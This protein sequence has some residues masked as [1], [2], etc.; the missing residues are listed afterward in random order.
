M[1]SAIKKLSTLVVDDEMMSSTIIS[2]MVKKS[3]YLAL[4]DSVDRADKARD[5]LRAEKI[6][7]LFLDINMPGMTGLELI[8]ELGKNT[9]HVILISARKEYAL[10]AFES[11][12]VVDYLL[13][14]V[15]PNR[16]AQ[17]VDRVV[18]KAKK[19]ANNKDFESELLTRAIRFHYSRNLTHF[20]PVISKQSKLG[21]T[22]PFLAATYGPSI[23][24][25]AIDLLE[26][27]EQQGFIN[28]N[29]FLETAYSCPNCYNGFLHYREVCT[30]C[31]SSDLKS[32]DLVHH[33]PCAYIAPIS[34]FE[35]PND[36]FRMICPKCNKKLKHIGVDYDKPSVIHTCRSCNKTFQDTLVYSKCMVCETDVEVSH[37]HKFTFYDYEITPKGELASLLDQVQLGKG[38]Q[39]NIHGTMDADLVTQKSF[40]TSFWEQSQPKAGEDI[41]RYIMSLEFVNADNLFNQIGDQ[42]YRSMLTDV[43]MQIKNALDLHDFVTYPTPYKMVFSFYQTDVNSAHQFAIQ[44]K[45][46][47]EKLI[48]DNYAFD[49]QVHA[50]YFALESMEELSTR[51]RRMVLNA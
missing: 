32:E 1:E 44:C 34:D 13:K 45:K 18:D 5:L 29:K 25:K 48:Q 43:T 11:G 2:A 31:H 20:T 40:I 30:N 14:P 36:S 28:K 12:V 21:Y 19:N 41:S 16:F 7:L 38:K 8:K 4:V 49:F 23:E 26:N 42:S 33:F 6:D 22:Y 51:L 47:L 10:E 37:L 50:E 17:A 9:P 24:E 27:A 35:D 46:F 3:P 39:R 15:S